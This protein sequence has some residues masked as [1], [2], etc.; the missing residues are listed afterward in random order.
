MPSVRPAV[1]DPAFVNLKISGPSGGLPWVFAAI[2][3]VI[4]AGGLAAEALPQPLTLEHVLSLSD[5]PS[6]TILEA[7]AN[8]ELGHAERDMAVAMNGIEAGLRGRLKLR[9]PQFDTLSTSPDDHRAGL[10]IRKRLYDFGRSE[11]H[12]AAAA[13]ATESAKHEMVEVRQH[14]RIELMGA[15]FTVILADLEF[16]RENEAMAGGF[17]RFDRAQQRAALGQVS[18]VDVLELQAQYEKI[19]TRR[20][21]AEN[22]QR[23]A[24]SRLA[25]ALNRPGDLPAD[26]VR[27]ELFS[28]ERVVPEFDDLEAVV[29]ESNAGLR[30]SRAKLTAARARIGA[31]KAQAN[32]SIDGEIMAGIQTRESSSANYL[33]GA[34]VLEIPLT[35]GGRMEADIRRHEAEYTRAKAQQLGAELAVRQRVLESWLEL[36]ALQNALREGRV[37][38]DYRELYLDRSRALYE[39]DVRSDLGTAM[40]ETSQARLETARAEFALALAWA[41]IDA[42]AGV[43]PEEM[44]RRVFAAPMDGVGAQ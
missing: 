42:L 13:A 2:S 29:L 30:M 26:L 3:L 31:A 28:L 20:F 25:L 21:A 35:T 44:V 22:A 4:S 6:A 10:V 33:S 9:R 15:F 37:V 11:H 40:V 38:E 32:P 7:G 18:E 14:R 36:G 19:R 12:L 43:S 1:A 41:T 23:A 34:L 8:I 17:I 39:L 5:E 16:A 27:P 24:R